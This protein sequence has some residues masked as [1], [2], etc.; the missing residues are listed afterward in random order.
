MSS[1]KDS[2]IELVIFFP[3]VSHLFSPP[4]HIC[5]QS[6]SRLSPI[7][8]QSGVPS[9]S[10]SVSPSLHS[11][12]PSA[13]NL[14]LPFIAHLFPINSLSVSLWFQVSGTSSPHEVLTAMRD[15]PEGSTRDQ[16][17]LLPLVAEVVTDGKYV[18]HHLDA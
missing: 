17:H 1:L 4:L 15:L 3:S 7:Y 5:F 2:A 8:F 18:L 13:S 16:D 10:P 6:V 9:I 11:C 14:G 12:C